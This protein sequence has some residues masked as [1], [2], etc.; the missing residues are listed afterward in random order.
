MEVMNRAELTQNDILVGQ[1][2]VTRSFGVSDDP[3]LMSMLSTGFYQRPLRT[4][5]QEVMFNAWDAHRMGNCQ[6]RPIDIYLNET[7]GLIIRD[8][9]PGIDPGEDDDNMHEIYCMYGGSTKR[10]MK[11][12]TGGFGLGSKSP[13]SY[14]ESFT[15]TSHFG[16]IKNMYLISRASESNGGKPGMT[17]LVRV[18]TTETGL[19]V[20]VPLKKGD[21]LK[22][23][24]FVKDVL[25]LSGIKAMIHL[26]EEADEYID[27]AQLD[28]GQYLIDENHRQGRIYAVY[29]GV[30]YEIPKFHE[31][32]SEFEFIELISKG[33]D[34]FVGFAPDTLSPLP[35]REG[36][37]M[38]EKSKESVK[39]TFELC[40]ERFENLVDPVIKA[41]F[42]SVLSCLKAMKIQGNF[43]FIEVAK[44]GFDQNA[45]GRKGQLRELMM[46][47]IP[48]DVPE[49]L[50]MIM[51]QLVI[52]QT[53]NVMRHVEPQRWVIHLVKEFIKAYPECKEL[54]FAS[55]KDEIPKVF[56]MHH[57][58]QTQTFVSEFTRYKFLRDQM[59]FIRQ[60]QEEFPDKED[61][62]PVMRIH[63]GEDWIP[64]EWDR[65][66][67]NVEK[68]RYGT[69]KLQQDDVRL[70]RASK[71]RSLINLWKKK[72]GQE[73]SF[74]MMDKTVMIVKNA[75]AL[76]NSNI[77]SDVQTHNSIM[78]GQHYY[79]DG[80]SVAIPAYIVYERRGAYEKA[81]EILTNMG[82]NVYEGKEPERK[83]YIPKAKQVPVYSLIDPRQ[84]EDW[85]S[86]N[87]NDQIIDPTHFF[88]ATQAT[89]KGYNSSER[90]ERELVYWFRKQNPKLVTINHSRSIETLK[91]AGAI[92][93]DEGLKVWYD[94]QSHDINRM[95][96]IIRATRISQWS[97]L[98]DDL[99][100]H[101][102]IQL[103][104]GMEPVDVSDNAFW[105]ETEGYQ[106]LMNTNFYPLKDLKR[107]VTSDIEDLWRQDPEAKN[108]RHMCEVTKVLNSST[109]SFLWS[110]T[111]TTGR[112]AFVDSVIATLKLFS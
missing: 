40:M 105:H 94:L 17:S 91:N 35:N 67:A 29:G 68:T 52:H 66:F 45:E 32:E 99:A 69:K 59:N 15:V 54:A 13:F 60:M 85:L 23:Y 73:L 110:D 83:V 7:T 4:M 37:N 30:R 56:P 5:I 108:I 101:P 10:K 8:Y 21:L 89:L 2:S 86:R 87:P 92:P 33:Y 39:A 107:K 97:N 111:K 42:K 103:E 96:N 100:K 71:G 22:A 34:L 28:A 48:P 58:D 79:Y 57:K 6:H 72:T 38:G 70:A 78:K 93:F 65:G 51:T 43:A 90:P 63:E 11:N 16:G 19:L 104:L 98:P 76:K 81:K 109:I 31:Y 106:Y 41:F 20:T 61:L 64:V 27:S 49:D 12:Q 1:K 44:Y 75:T 55:L 50:W 53:S 47:E 24:E 95:M 14:T 88:Y 26:D 74:C 46:K 77:P 80:V 112:D 9:G 3:M 25:F 82:F 62:I 84:S 36:L 102:L 18:P